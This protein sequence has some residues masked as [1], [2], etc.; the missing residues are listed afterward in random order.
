IYFKTSSGTVS[1]TADVLPV[2][3]MTITG[4]GKVGI[5]TSSPS[6]DLEVVGSVG[7]TQFCL[8]G[9]CLTALPTGGSGGG[10]VT[11]LGLGPGILGGPILFTATLSLDV[12]TSSGQIVQVGPGDLVNSS[13]IPLLTRS[14]FSANAI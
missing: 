1:G 4:E 5:G 12:G 2:T 11:S 3:R 8:L 9:D 14:H 13:V 10:T 6:Y 7:A